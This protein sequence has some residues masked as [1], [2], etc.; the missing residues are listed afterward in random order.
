M[1]CKGSATAQMPPMP[2]YAL[3]AQEFYMH[4]GRFTD[5]PSLGGDRV[6]GTLK[7]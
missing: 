4:R 2:A 1:G 5:W 7:D 3:E 6:C